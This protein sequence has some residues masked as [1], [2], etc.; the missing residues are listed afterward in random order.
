MKTNTGK[1]AS[2]S[3][4]DQNK[5][6]LES[7]HLLL[8]AETH[9]LTTRNSLLSKCK[10]CG[11]NSYTVYVKDYNDKEYS[12]ILEKVTFTAKPNHSEDVSI[13][14]VELLSLLTIINTIDISSTAIFI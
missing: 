4:R 12:K 9:D 5:K 10:I 14:F 11:C 6:L 7:C 3:L 2:R 13:E 1:T 8:S